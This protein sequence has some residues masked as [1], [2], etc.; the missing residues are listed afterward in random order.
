MPGRRI[1][2]ENLCLRSDS[3][4]SQ[5]GEISRRFRPGKWDPAFAKSLAS[6]TIHLNFSRE[7]EML[8]NKALKRLLK[9]FW[10][11]FV[12]A[13][14]SKWHVELDHFIAYG[15]FPNLSD[16]KIFSEKIAYRKLYDRDPR[17]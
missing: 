2:G 15:R 5:N 1:I 9:P 3:I 14:P 4:C 10:R 11:V 16:P 12:D 13:L 7:R 17:M 6:A 8:M